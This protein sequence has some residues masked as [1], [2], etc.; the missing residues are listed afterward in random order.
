MHPFDKFPILVCNTD[1]KTFILTIELTL[2]YI[3]YKIHLS[4]LAI[5]LFSS[6]AGAA[7]VRDQG[8]PILERVWSADGCIGKFVIRE[9]VMLFHQTI[10]V[11]FIASGLLILVFKIRDMIRY[12]H[13]QS[14]KVIYLTKQNEIKLVYY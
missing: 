10:E 4:V 9:L 11:N 1:V 12:I 14:K 5:F 8:T 3:L 2:F 6:L 13:F 7:A